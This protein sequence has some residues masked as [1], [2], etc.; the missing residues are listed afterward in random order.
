MPRT[1]AY[2]CKSELKPFFL[3][4]KGRVRVWSM[5]HL[6]HQN[7]SNETTKEKSMMKRWY[8]PL[9]KMIL[10]CLLAAA[11]THTQP[12][13]PVADPRCVITEGSA[14]FTILTPELIRMEWSEQ[15]SFEDRASLVFI[16]RRLEPPHF[17]MRRDTG[18]LVI[19]TDRLRL[20]Y[21]PDGS[22][23]SSSNLRISFELN[24]KTTRLVSRTGGSG[25]SWRARSGLSTA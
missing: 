9:Q 20:E 8:A 2:L 17:V 3:P 11:S 13:N 16:N 18:W 6:M 1:Y 14:R 4:S 12:L 23:F 25:K 10:V 24:G 19:Q 5:N 21:F 15:R 7:C 22:S